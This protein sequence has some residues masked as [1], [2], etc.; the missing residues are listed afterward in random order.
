MIAI[1]SIALRSLA[2]LCA[3]GFLVANLDAGG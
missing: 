1:H 3:T 2:E